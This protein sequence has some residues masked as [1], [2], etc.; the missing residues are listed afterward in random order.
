MNEILKIIIIF[1]QKKDINTTNKKFK[2]K[3]K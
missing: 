2:T 1:N 3:N